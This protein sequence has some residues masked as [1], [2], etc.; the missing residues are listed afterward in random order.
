M[1]RLPRAWRENTLLGLS[2]TASLA[3]FILVVVE[4]NKDDAVGGSTP[5]DE[6]SGTVTKPN[7]YE[8]INPW[9]RD[10]APYVRLVQ[11]GYHDE[12]LD[13]TM[14]VYDDMRTHFGG[15]GPI[16]YYYVENG[17]TS[18]AT[19]PGY[20]TLDE[21]ETHYCKYFTDLF[22]CIAAEDFSTIT[23]P[24]IQ[25]FYT[26]HMSIFQLLYPSWYASRTGAELAE[27]VGGIALHEATHS[28][29]F[30]YGN[31][32]SAY[33]SGPIWW[34]EGGADYYKKMLPIH[35]PSLTRGLYNYTETKFISDFTGR[36][37]GYLAAVGG[38]VTIANGETS[39]EREALG[40]YEVQVLY[41]GGSLAWLW[42]HHSSGLNFTGFDGWR[43]DLLDN[44]WLHVLQTYCGCSNCTSE[45]FDPFYD[46]FHVALA[47]ETE[48]L[49]VIES[50]ASLI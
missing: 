18:T 5:I 24:F 28:L 17:G 21:M 25:A 43:Q 11:H 30:A 7:P 23:N 29:Q 6:P 15:V 10:G 35:M 31:Y 46:P 48:F 20:Y 26:G 27:F 36:R 12:T 42:C 8:N 41:E 19:G 45:D 33:P 16:D 4:V 13:I 22:G 9:L 14:G 44:G 37:Q 47:D 1:I 50:T 3:A 40:Q 34:L 49:A 2:V 32:L 38:G 39:A